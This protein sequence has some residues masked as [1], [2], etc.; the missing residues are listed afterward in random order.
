MLSR[1]LLLYSYTY[2]NWKAEVVNGVRMLPNFEKLTFYQKRPLLWSRDLI[3]ILKEIL[4]FCNIHALPFQPFNFYYFRQIYDL[5]ISW[6]Y[7]NYNLLKLFSTLKK[8]K[9][10]TSWNEKLFVET[11]WRKEVKGPYLHQ[12]EN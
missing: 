1:Q 7:C 3:L 5:R 11:N 10:K 9:K 8:R 6:Y 4:Y 12:P 2:I